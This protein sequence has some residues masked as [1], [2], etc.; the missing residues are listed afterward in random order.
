MTAVHD[1]REIKYPVLQ[2]ASRGLLLRKW[3]WE[4]IQGSFHNIE[5]P[6]QAKGMTDEP[7][8]WR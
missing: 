5:G 2:I 3:G 1:S 8:C 4:R 7:R 6:N